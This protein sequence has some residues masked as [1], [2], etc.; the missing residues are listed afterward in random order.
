[1]NF[2]T[3]ALSGRGYDWECP[4]YDQECSGYLP[5]P[6]SL[7]NAGNSEEVLANIILRENL[8]V[9]AMVICIQIA[10]ES[11]L[12]HMVKITFAPTAINHFTAS[13]LYNFS[14]FALILLNN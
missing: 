5:T 6:K 4:G 9:D 10:V 8:L 3:W 13:G 14:G 12:C 1:M 11:S 2:F 7:Q